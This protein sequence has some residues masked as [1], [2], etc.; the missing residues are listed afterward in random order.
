MNSLKPE[1]LRQAGSGLIF[2]KE[3][4][5][6]SAAE[7]CVRFCSGG[8][9]SAWPASSGL[10]SRTLRGRACLS[11]RGRLTILG[12]GRSTSSMSEPVPGHQPVSR[13][14]RRVGSP[15]SDG[16][17]LLASLLSLSGRWHRQEGAT[18]GSFNQAGAR[19]Q[20]GPS[21]TEVSLEELGCG[22]W[23]S[24]LRKLLKDPRVL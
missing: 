22:R 7:G 8:L 13:R 24:I 2:Q 23:V 9:C 11:R 17:G 5:R 21:V 3:A 19:V 4:E 10:W 6:M 20:W 18:A 1:P 16:Q 15:L 14:P 12:Q